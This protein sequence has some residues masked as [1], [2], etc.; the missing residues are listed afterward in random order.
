MALF[1]SSIWIG[2]DWI[3]WTKQHQLIQSSSLQCCFFSAVDNFNRILSSDFKWKFSDLNSNWLC[4]GR[5]RRALF[6]PL[7]L[8][9]AK[10][11]SS[12]KRNMYQITCKLEKLIRATLQV[13]FNRIVPSCRPAICFVMI[14][15]INEIIFALDGSRCTLSLSLSL[16]TISRS[17]SFWSGI[18]FGLQS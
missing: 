14:K 12:I 17:V 1:S 7:F 15:I 10:N 18:H 8:C 11:H 4:F 16:S 5:F 9:P 13:L 6:S 3:F 2:Y